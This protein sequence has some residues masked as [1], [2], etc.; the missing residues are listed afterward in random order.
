MS[1][2]ILAVD[3][4][5][6]I[7]AYSAST[8][9]MQSS[10]SS[11]RPQARRPSTSSTEGDAIDVVVLDRMIP[12]MDGLEVLRT[13]RT[14]QNSA[15]CRSF[16]DGPSPEGVGRRGHRGGRVLLSHK[17]F[18]P[19]CCS[20]SFVRP[21]IDGAELTDLRADPG[22]RR[23]APGSRRARFSIRTIDV[24]RGSWTA[25]LAAPFPIPDRVALGLLG[26]FSTPLSTGTSIGYQEKTRR[27]G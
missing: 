21:S 26:F 23:W 16:S 5:R 24:T 20:R 10:T 6:S 12:G 14:R 15:K 25:P 7:F 17:P 4:E 8:Q 11:P 27:I 19:R 13:M 9:A 18:E 3:D 22:P 2:R 1:P